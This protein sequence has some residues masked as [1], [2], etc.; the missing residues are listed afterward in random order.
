MC[1]RALRRCPNFGRMLGHSLA[2][3]L[4]TYSHLARFARY[5]YLARFARYA[6]DAR[7]IPGTQDEAARPVRKSSSL[8][9]AAK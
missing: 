5:A 2:I 3:L 4:T 8:G 1:G 9:F 7:D 6:L